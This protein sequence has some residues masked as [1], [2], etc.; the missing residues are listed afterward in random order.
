MDPQRW[1]GGGGVFCL[2]CLQY[3]QFLH[4]LSVS[5]YLARTRRLRGAPCRGVLLGSCHF[6]GVPLGSCHVFGVLLGSCHVFG[7]LLGSCRVFGVLLGPCHVFG[8]LL[9]SSCHVFDVL[10]GSS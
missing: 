9:G 4:L 8:V 7:V 6:F 10:L 2:S 3:V 5:K 1:L